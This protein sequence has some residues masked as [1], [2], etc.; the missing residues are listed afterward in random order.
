[1]C[2]KGQV[3]A[4][5]EMQQTGEREQEEELDVIPLQAKKDMLYQKIEFR[6]VNIA[7]RNFVLFRE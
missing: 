6:N 4:E 3:P 2:T 5:E 1:M 7:G